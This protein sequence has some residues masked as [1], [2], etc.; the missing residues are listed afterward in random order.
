MPRSSRHHRS[1]VL[2]ASLALILAGCET[3]GSGN[4]DPRELDAPGQ[5]DLGEN[6]PGSGD[7]GAGNED[8]PGIN[9]PGLDTDD[10]NDQG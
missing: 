2:L 1:R 7:G 9:D 3:S 10:E 5:E 8:S 6:A 4:D